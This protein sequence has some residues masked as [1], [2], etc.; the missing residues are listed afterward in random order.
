MQNQKHRAHTGGCVTLPLPVPAGTKSGALVVL[1]T[2]GLY[3]VAETAAAT[4]GQ[5][6]QGTAPQGLVEGQASVSLPGIVLTLRVA[7]ADLA[8][9]GDFA[10]V[11]RSAAGAY[12]ATASDTFVGYRLNATTLALRSN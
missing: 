8:A 6:N 12:T 11:Y 1:G 10:K 4:A 7:P 3:G 9:F 2:A 5:V